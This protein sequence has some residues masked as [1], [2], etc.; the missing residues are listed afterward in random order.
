MTISQKSR[1]IKIKDKLPS[2][3]RITA[4][5]VYRL[6]FGGTMSTPETLA[7]VDLDNKCI[8]IRDDLS[9]R[10]TL[11]ALIHEL[12]H[13]LDFEH[14]TAVVEGVRFKKKKGDYLTERQTCALEHAL[15]H[16]L[17]LNKWL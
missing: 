8:Y 7:E 15:F 2:S 5:V 6:Y 3:F 12:I 10:D 11:K 13:A 14:E 4:K 17:R 9:E 1:I 16:F